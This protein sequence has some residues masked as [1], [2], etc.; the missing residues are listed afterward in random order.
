[1]KEGDAI[2]AFKAMSFVFAVILAVF[3]VTLVS[4]DVILEVFVATFD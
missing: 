1:V 3:V 2:F 4:R